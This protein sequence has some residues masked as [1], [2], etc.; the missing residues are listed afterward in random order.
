MEIPVYVIEPKNI[1]V[2]KFIKDSNE[3]YY[4]TDKL[5]MLY[6]TPEMKINKIGYINENSNTLPVIIAYD[7]NQFQIVY[8]YPD[9][10]KTS[11]GNIAKKIGNIKG[12]AIMQIPQSKI[13][14]KEL[15]AK[16]LIPPNEDILEKFY[17]EPDINTPGLNSPTVIF[18]CNDFDDTGTVNSPEKQLHLLTEKI[19]MLEFDL[20]E[21]RH[22]LKCFIQ[23]TY[24]IYDDIVYPLPLRSKGQFGSVISIKELQLLQ[25]QDNIKEIKYDPFILP[26]GGSIRKQSRMVCVYTK[27]G[28]LHFCNCVYNQET[29]NISDEPPMI[30]DITQEQPK[31]QLLKSSNTKKK[32]NKY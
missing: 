18:S 16:N 27:S 20:Q 15:V 30:S 11:E 5:Q 9:A 1:L 32:T 26:L 2:Y 4:T 22:I 29:G 19:K 31:L 25:K 28:L 21:T 12:M 24:R 17:E 7:N 8:S 10:I 23:G 14:T 6:V 13:G 3:F